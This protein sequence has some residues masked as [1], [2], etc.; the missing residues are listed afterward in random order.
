MLKSK[1]SFVVT[2]G[3][4]GAVIALHDGNEI[5]NKI[6]LESLTEES[7]NDLKILF[8]KN[9]FIP[10]FILLDTT[11]QSYK[12][13]SYPQMR[14]GDLEHIIKRD[15]ASDGDHESLKSYII[16]KK[17][18]SKNNRN[19]NKSALKTECLFI[20]AATGEI[21]S[22]WIDFLLEMPNHVPGIYLLPIESFSFLNL[23]KKDIISRSKAKKIGSEQ[24]IFLILHNKV[25]GVRQIVFNEQGIV[26]TRCMN[27]SFNEPDFLEKYEQDIYSTF[28]Y[29]KRL[30]PDLHVSEMHIA[31]IFSN[32]I[33]EKIKT[34]ASPELNFI[35]YT[36]FEAAEKCNLKKIL[37]VNANYCD[38]ILS[39]T[40][41]NSKKL[42]K[43][44][45]FK[46]KILEKYF[47]TL[48]SS[49]YFN[50][51]MS[52]AI[53]FACLALSFGNQ[54]I[55]NLIEAEKRRALATQELRQAKS[56][57]KEQVNI[58]ENGN[59]ID[60]E[61]I[62]DFGKIEESIGSVGIDIEKYYAKMRFLKNS[63][64]KL[65]SFSYKLQSFNYK[66]PA[67]SGYVMSFNGDLTNKSGD[68]DDLFKSFDV[69]TRKTKQ[70]FPKET[71]KYNEIPRNIDFVQK[72]YTFPIEFTLS[73]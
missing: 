45:N 50:V 10:I 60:A 41:S 7:K 2:I 12:K 63:D 65:T 21:V 6:F 55:Q 49:F 57:E 16:E 15:L 3:N 39:K 54:N 59:V 70:N 47:I 64:V 18:R 34:I 36:P 19:L 61:R 44:T 14:L 68:I 30:I 52:F 24:I 69:L 67:K 46:I 71:I 29:L 35:N 20:S 43:F 38:L 66:S 11:D 37:P 17:S 53:F 23:I 1:K 5:K 8:S 27:Y 25:S 40:F 22:P 73:N 33:L 51:G 4:Y 13:K 58:T 62:I 72:Y 48:K 31:N 9:H 56:P 28:E 42:L 26:F 32:E